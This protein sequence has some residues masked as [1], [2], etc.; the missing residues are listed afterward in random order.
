MNDANIIDSR[1]QTM[2][3]EEYINERVDGQIAWYDRKSII[4]KKYFIIFQIITLGASAS[5]PVFSIFSEN[6]SWARV[7]IAIL[8]SAT[9]ITTGIVSLYQFREHWIE[10]RATAESLKHEKYMFQTGTGLYAEKEAFSLL[11][12]RVEALLSQENTAWH[13]LLKT[14][15]SEN[16]ES[17]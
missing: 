13:Q 12:E 9:A 15:K 1:Q 3:S 17:N 8:G 2:S 16:S 5:I 4:N 10:Y 14:P 6:N 7:L 11:V